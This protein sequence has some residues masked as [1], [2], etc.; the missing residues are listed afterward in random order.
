[1]TYYRC[2]K[3]PDEG[4]VFFPAC[5]TEFPLWGNVVMKYRF[6]KKHLKDWPKI[7]NGVFN[8]VGSMEVGSN[9]K[10]QP[11]SYLGG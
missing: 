6:N 11:T 8:F 1:L 4:K 10:L 3:D 7:H 9:K 2:G 5:E